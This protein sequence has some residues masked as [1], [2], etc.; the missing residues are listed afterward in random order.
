[1]PATVASITASS[2]GLQVNSDLTCAS[3]FSY[4]TNIQMVVNS[5]ATLAL[6]GSS[7]ATTGNIAG[8]G[9]IAVAAMGTLGF[10]TIGSE[11]IAPTVNVAGVF[12]I[13]SGPGNLTIPSLIN[14]GTV[15]VTAGLTTLACSAGYT[16]S[17]GTTQITLGA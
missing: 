10:T 1:M 16:Q 3:G 13:N 8:S 11:S 15:T 5:P 9:T 2:A 6:Q 12:N 14:T 4:T 17:A 7:N